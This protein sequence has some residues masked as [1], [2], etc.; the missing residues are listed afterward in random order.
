ML[1]SCVAVRLIEGSGSARFFASNSP[2]SQFPRFRAPWPSMTP[3]LETTG[4]GHQQGRVRV[5]DLAVVRCERR[6]ACVCAGE[7]FRA[8]AERR[9][10]AWARPARSGDLDEAVTAEE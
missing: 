6:V 4:R 8:A 3:N 2:L 1:V 7:G 5:G 9:R 10:G